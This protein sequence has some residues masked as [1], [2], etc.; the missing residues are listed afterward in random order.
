MRV[1]QLLIISNVSQ[2]LHRHSQILNSALTFRTLRRVVLVQTKSNAQWMVFAEA[3]KIA[4]TLECVLWVGRSALISPVSV[5]N[6]PNARQPLIADLNSSVLTSLALT[7]LKSVL[8]SSHAL[9][10]LKWSVQTVP[11]FTVN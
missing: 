3:K 2:L 11:V 1:A 6:S 4:L 5:E 7:R 10:P 9:T 8:T